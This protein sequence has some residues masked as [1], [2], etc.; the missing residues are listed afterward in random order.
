MSDSIPFKPFDDDGEVRIYYNGFL[1]HWRQKDCTYF[2]T[3]RLADSVPKPVIDEWQF[4][5]DAWLA[6]RG[7]DLKLMPLHQAMKMLSQRDQ[8]AFERHFAGKLFAFLDKGYGACHLRDHHIGKIVANAIGHFHGT[9][10]YSGDFVV[11]PNHVHAL[12]TPIDEFELEEVLHSIKS[13]TANQIN[14]CL[15]R[16]GTL[17]MEESYD[18]I[19]RDGDE[20]LRIQQYIKQNPEKAGLKSTEFQYQS[21]TYQLK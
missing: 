13:Y 4:E 6:A 19:V 3:F 20:L 17:W 14:R 7:I 10:L 21:A 15:G 8:Q 2:V 18:H 5:R 1:P 9:R 12:L 11:M 16:S